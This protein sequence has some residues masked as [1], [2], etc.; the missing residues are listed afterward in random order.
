VAATTADIIYPGNESKLLHQ[1]G[2]R[3]EH[4]RVALGHA[5]FDLVTGRS[6]CADCGKGFEGLDDL[7][8][9]VV[10]HIEV[11]GRL[12]RDSPSWSICRDCVDANDAAK[13]TS[14]PVE[15]ANRLVH[16]WL[17]RH[18]ARRLPHPAERRR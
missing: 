3:P 13:G 15:L 14:R 8:C 6:A 5:L 12:N 2:A 1:V 7:G 10:S 9:G 18:G 16:E 11:H 4:C 17:S